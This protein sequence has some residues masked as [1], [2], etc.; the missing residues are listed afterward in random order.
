MKYWE[1][2]DWFWC[3]LFNVTLIIKQE[4]SFERPSGYDERKFPPQKFTLDDTCAI[5]IVGVL[6]EL[7]LITARF[8][9]WNYI[10][11]FV[12]T[13][14][15]TVAEFDSYE[16]FYILV[17]SEISH[18]KIRPE[19]WRRFRVYRRLNYEDLQIC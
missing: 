19:K 9:A 4:I 18:I 8:I 13:C 17:I 16:C 12:D 10:T 15:P 6:N 2:C 1:I 7:I 5:N 11:A 3:F 14:L